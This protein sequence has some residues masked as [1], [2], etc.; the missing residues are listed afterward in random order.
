MTDPSVK[1]ARNE[2]Y[3]I[4]GGLSVAIIVD[5][6]IAA[7][8]FVLSFA[9]LRDL[10]EQAGT[11]HTLSW[12]F[13][14]AIDAAIAA[15]TLSAVLL[16]KL[17]GAKVIAISSGVFA[18]AALIVSI[19][20][21]AYHAYVN[22][23]VTLDPRAAAGLAVIPPVLVLVLTHLVVG[24][25]GALG[26]ARARYTAAVATAADRIDEAEFFAHR[27]RELAHATAN[28]TEA[29]PEPAET[30]PPAQ[31]EPEAADQDETDSSTALFAHPT[32]PELDL[33][34][35]AEFLK[36]EPKLEHVV[37]KTAELK[38]EHPEATW[39]ALGEAVGGAR[40][41]T[42]IRRWE[43][44]LSAADAAGYVRYLAPLT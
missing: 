12:I 42:A 9:V 8:S 11:P 20:C 31:A 4:A 44:F 26:L 3:L 6:A 15:A 35:L 13:P 28:P 7:G 27:E 23:L 2:Y 39:E 43:R 18:G 24:Q 29:T 21:N 5:I 34:L 25:I 32:E 30:G 19:V 41:S 37:R 16:S 22:P 33:G 10:I 17:E 14:L 1:A 40:H 36:T 38:F